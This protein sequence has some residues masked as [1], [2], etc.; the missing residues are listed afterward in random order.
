MNSGVYHIFNTITNKGYIGSSK[1]ID[2]RFKEHANELLKG[3]HRNK[4]LQNSFDK[5][6]KDC[7]EFKILVTCP[8]D[9]IYKLE[10]W[11][12]DKGYFNNEYN[13]CRE[14]L[15][16]PVLVFTDEL[17]Q[18]ISEGSKIRANTID[19]KLRLK[20]I[21]ISTW[22]NSD[23][24]K[25]MQEIN[26]GA[27]HPQCTIS[28]EKARQIKLEIFQT[29][30]YYGKLPKLAK[31]FNVTLGIVKSIKYEQSWKFIKI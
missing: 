31:K 20:S 7:F 28:E 9:Y 17:K 19:E 11:F 2:K 22:K 3:K 12:L 13:I 29:E 5:Y 26:K 4:H 18:K 14:V 27:N 10:Q 23:H 25:F 15:L 8:P 1:R 24:K 30:D 16:P 21:A 6:G